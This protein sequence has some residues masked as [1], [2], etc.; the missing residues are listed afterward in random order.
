MI[1]QI[2]TEKNK[3]DYLDFSEDIQFLF[4]LFISDIFEEISYHEPFTYIDDLKL[5]DH[6]RSN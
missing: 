4:I 3:V 6:R 1:N 2:L 5:V